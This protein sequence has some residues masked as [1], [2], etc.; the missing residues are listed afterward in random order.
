MILTQSPYTERCCCNYGGRCI[1]STKKGQPRTHVPRADYRSAA[2][3]YEEYSAV[4]VEPIYA[5]LSNG[6]LTGGR[7]ESYGFRNE[8][9]GVGTGTTPATN[10]TTY[11]SSATD[12]IGDQL[13]TVAGSSQ[14]YGNFE[15]FSE[16][17]EPERH[18]VDACLTVLGDYGPYELSA[19]AGYN[20]GEV[21][22]LSG[23]F[24]FQQPEQTFAAASNDAGMSLPKDLDD[25]AACVWSSM[26]S[27]ADADIGGGAPSSD[28]A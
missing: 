17:T 8:Q 4:Q 12:Q 14:T 15:S 13:Q 27:M 2:A 22:D 6:E 5:K 19:T 23:F 26:T 16:P 9:D 20:Q 7:V 21:S 25:I 24:A 28:V 10:G 3:R 1:C 18:S 11:A